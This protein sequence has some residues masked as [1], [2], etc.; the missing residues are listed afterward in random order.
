MLFPA[1]AVRV[2]WAFCLLRKVDDTPVLPGSV[3]QMEA[4]TVDILKYVTEEFTKNVTEIFADNLVGIY[5]HG[6]GVMGCFNP[7]KSDIDL[8]VVVKND[9]PDVDKKAFMDMVVALNANAP[10]KGIEVSIVKSNVCKPFV[11]P[12]PFELHFSAM[13]LNWYKDNPDNYVQN[14]KGTDEDLA[15][16]FT[17]IT[18]RGVCLAGKPIDEVFGEVPKDAYMDSIRGDIAEAEQDILEDTMYIT[19][20]LARALAFVREGLVLSK[21]EGGEWGLKNLPLEYHPLIEKA[22]REY[23]GSGETVYDEERAVSYAK[24]MLTEIG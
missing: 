3:R 21:R 2:R 5:L 4:I 20:N 1:I 9:I 15:A 11:Y 8:I 24:Y 10:S 17:I 16:H 22:L 14:M 18:H 6:S 23:A 12:T 19:L 7:E 13:H